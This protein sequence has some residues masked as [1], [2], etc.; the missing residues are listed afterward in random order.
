MIEKEKKT[1]M[2][3]ILALAGIIVLSFM[4]DDAICRSLMDKQP[5]SETSINF[6]NR[7]RFYLDLKTK[8]FLKKMALK[9]KLLVELIQNIT[10]EVQARGKSGVINGDAGFDLV[11]E[12]VNSILKQYNEEIQSIKYIVS[13]LDKLELTIQKIDD[14]KLL[15]EVEQLK[16]N[17]MGVLDKQKLTTSQMTKQQAANM[18][19]EYSKEINQLLQFYEQ[20]ELFQTKASSIGDIEIVK[21]L[22]RE[23]QRIIKIFEESR[24]AGTTSDKLVKDYIT[25]ATSV[26]EILKKMDSLSEKAEV[27]STLKV[28]IDDVRERV[29]A[30]IDQR[31]L[32]LFGIAQQDSFKGVTVSDYFKSWRSDRTAEFQV[33]YTRYKVIRDNLIRTGAQEERHRMMEHEIADALLNYSEQNYDLADMQFQQ[34]YD[35]YQEYYSS[36]DGLIFFR[37]EANYANHYYDVARDGYSKI[38]QE[39]PNSQYVGQSY[40]HLMMICYTYNLYDEFFKYFSKVK[41]IQS[42]DREDLNEAYYLAGYVHASQRRYQDAKTILENVKDDSK[43][44]LTAQYLLG[45]VLTNLEKYPQAMSLFEIIATKQNYPWTDLTFS[46]ILN[47]SL[48]RLGYLHFQ[49][50]EYDRAINYFDQV[51]KG[52]KNYDESLLGQA[53]ANLKKGQYDNAINKV[54]LICSSYLLSNYTY[55]ALVLSAHCKRIQN[56]TD[57]ALRDL[58][59]VSKAKHVLGQVEEYNDE[60]KKILKQLDEL[61]VLEDNILDHQDRKLYPQV[62]KIRDLINDALMAFRYRGTVTSRMLDEYN[63]E[64]KILIRQIEEFDSIIKYAEEH[65]NPG[66]GAD[67]I[68]QRG[69]LIALLEKYQFEQSAS[70]IGSFTDYPVAAKEGEV[71]Y[72]RG[73]V[74]KLVGELIVEKQ[75]V[76][77]DLEIVAELLAVSD[78]NKK[79]DAVV[80]LE[81][82]EEDLNDLNNQLNQFQVWLANHHIE[83]MNPETEQWANLSG[84]G[85]S[86]INFVSFRERIKQIGSY[87]KNLTH[88]D[89]VLKNKQHELE[90]RI[91]RFDSEVRKIQKEMETEKTRLEKLEKEKYFQDLYFETKTKEIETEPGE[92][93]DEINRLFNQER[94]KEF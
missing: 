62:V 70:G 37:S 71:I 10:T 47:E 43:Y 29:I 16:D 19:H 33:R 60:R 42:I 69:R 87:S 38:I 59:Y 14:L 25:E 94:G 12:K 78:E 75:R 82:I 91:W 58:R 56:R 89:D 73:I 11:D 6:E 85:M 20:I 36:L 7:L 18:I 40:L 55:E 27:D 44:Y 72:R 88:I 46:I 77:K 63:D 26:V 41:D 4:N 66:M 51:S 35:A 5:K 9:E 79:M 2:G 90:Q 81:I 83:E 24:M 30:N 93:F 31:I 80:D 34:I 54:D 57:E 86:D 8:R 39:Y 76:Q 92:G 1:A 48:L 23:K 65:G 17:L 45:I 84:F 64:R 21:Q 13:E 68:K 15:D 67:A 3:W 74:N 28:N 52:Y 50:G 49:R 61:E 53:W 32:Q 22:D